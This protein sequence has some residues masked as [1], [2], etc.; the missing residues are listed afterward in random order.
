MQKNYII[1]VKRI[2]NVAIGLDQNLPMDV[3]SRSLI[4][5][6]EM[7]IDHAEESP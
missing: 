3:W 7:M 6:S 5:F 4:K 1:L 2:C